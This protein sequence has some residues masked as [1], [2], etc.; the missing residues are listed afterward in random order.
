V[1]GTFDILAAMQPGDHLY[2]PT[3]RPSA[4][5]YERYGID[6]DVIAFTDCFPDLLTVINGA[7]GP[8]MAVIDVKASDMMKFA[9]RIQV[10]L[11]ALILRDVIEEARIDLTV[12]PKGGVWLFEQPEPEWFDLVY[13]VPPLET[14]LTDD[15]TKI[16]EA[17]AEDAFWHLYFRCEWCDYY[18]HCRTE[19]EEADSISL[20]PYLSNFGERHLNDQ[21]INTVRDLAET[22]EGG[23]GGEVLAGSASLEG[24]ER[25]LLKAIAA[26]DIRGRRTAP[27]SDRLAS[28]YTL[29]F[30]HLGDGMYRIDPGQVEAEID[31]GTF[32]NF[33]ITPDTPAGKQARLAY[34]DFAYRKAF[35]APRNPDVALAA[36]VDKVTEDVY[37]FELR[38]GRDFTKPAV[39][40]V[41]FLENR[42]TDWNS[43][44]VVGELSDMDTEPNPW[45]VRLLRDPVGTTQRLTAPRAIRAAAIKVAHD[46]ELTP[47]QREALVE[48]LDQDVQAI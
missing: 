34:H 20:I 19:A 14:F 28:E 45:F 1:T 29:R 41:V 21:G 23:R 35:H 15:V 33:I 27:E 10:G 9:H 18:S 17:P 26:L 36:V 22:L 2:Q 44:R 4:G 5:F 25:Q 47:S 3:L 8:E 6:P 11:Y 37:R 30:T 31:L 24:R 39:G 13:I 16:L 43:E 48:V 7:D 38:P 42:F 32:P 40:D 46:H 12:S